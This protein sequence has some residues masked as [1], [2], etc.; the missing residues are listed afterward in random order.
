MFQPSKICA[1]TRPPLTFTANQGNDHHTACLHN[2]L[3]K[4]SAKTRWKIFGENSPE[5]RWKILVKNCRK[6][7]PQA[8]GVTKLLTKVPG[9]CNKTIVKSF[10]FM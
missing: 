6:I 5:T 7:L 10:S 9:L 2:I 8:V 4:I 3:S 1:L